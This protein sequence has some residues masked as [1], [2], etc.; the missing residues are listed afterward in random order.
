MTLDS[1]GKMSAV[2][3]ISL[4]PTNATVLGYPQKIELPEDSD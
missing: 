3:T 2:Q 4:S 1:P